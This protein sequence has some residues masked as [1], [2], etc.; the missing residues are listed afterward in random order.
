MI[1]L[2]LPE[3]LISDDYFRGVLSDARDLVVVQSVINYLGHCPIDALWVVKSRYLMAGSILLYLLLL[4]TVQGRRV[5]SK[6]PG[7]GIKHRTNG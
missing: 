2:S 3:T 7:H 1:L 5:R 4:L 6:I